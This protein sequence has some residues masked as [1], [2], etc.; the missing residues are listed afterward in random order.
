MSNV[1]D[2][3]SEGWIDA[4]L[5]DLGEWKGGGTPSKSN[6]SFWANGTVP[7]VSP[8]DMKRFYLDDAE[9]KITTD[10]I[11]NSSAQ[12]LPVDSVLVVTRS[13]ILERTLPVAINRVAVATNQDL[14][15]LLP[16]DG[17]DPRYIA[18]LL[19]RHDQR[20]R[21]EC[22]KAGTT[23]ASVDL[24]KLKAFKCGLAPL[25][26]QRRI[27]S[28]IEALQE[29]SRNAREALAEVGPLLEQFRQSLLAAAFSGRLTAD[30]RAAHPD[31]EPASELLAR[32]R[33][34][35]RQRW[36]QSELAKYKAKGTKPP[37]NWQDKYQEPNA[38]DEVAFADL[39]DLTDGWFWTNMDCISHRVS[40]GHVGPTS[41]FYCDADEGIPFLRSQ[42][43]RPR[44]L[45]TDGLNYITREFHNEL[46]KSQLHA[47]DILVVRVGA[48]RGDTCRVPEGY[49]EL[50][51]ANIV[52]AQPCGELSPF[53]ELF[54]Q[55]TFG[56]TLLLGMS[57][58]SAQGVINTKSVAELPIPVCSYAEQAEIITRLDAAFAGV[59]AIVDEVTHSESA[60]TQ[61]DQSILA[62]AFRGELVPQD[63][64]DEPASELLA[65]IRS[66][67]EKLTKPKKSRTRQ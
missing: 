52:F 33:T 2:V 4:T 27:V 49:D 53:I 32:I 24:P 15:A 7:W 46:Q 60:L 3:L 40:V 10:A 57:T 45:S 67:R 19:K 35:R 54:C 22:S 25:A 26:E 14:K 29:R 44:R 18:Y 58:G 65:R 55:S 56:Q 62:K 42:N 41:A 8:K 37:N 1:Y 48:N 64:R 16:V 36:E 39:P 11:K 5:G 43:V 61:L 51:C 34:E 17:I 50:N 38:L 13:G 20:L 21:D 31:V 6:L 9:D 28:K 30:W 63:P 66:T 12:L 23:V 59:N 47:G